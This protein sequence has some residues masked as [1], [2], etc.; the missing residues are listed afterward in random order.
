[1]K[2]QQKEETEEVKIVSPYT[3]PVKTNNNKVMSV[4]FI[5]LAVLVLLVVFWA[6]KEITINNTT[7]NMVSYISK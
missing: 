5:I 6:I 4:V 7:T 3:T 1:M 2:E